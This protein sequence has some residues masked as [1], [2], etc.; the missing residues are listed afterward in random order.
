M[1]PFLAALSRA[2]KAFD[3]VSVFRADLKLS[4]KFLTFVLVALFPAAFLLSDRNFFIADLVIGMG[5]F[6]H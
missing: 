1:T 3:K 4:I 6:Y 5:L 2:E